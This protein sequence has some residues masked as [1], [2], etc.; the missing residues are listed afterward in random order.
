MRAAD[1]VI[2]ILRQQEDLS[3]SLVINRI[4]EDWVKRRTMYAPN[5]IAQTLDIPL[6]GVIP[7][8]EEVLRCLVT[9]KTLIES[10]ARIWQT[11]D[12]ILRSLLGE[13]SS[14]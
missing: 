5:V 9:R 7:E 14:Q 10:D 4:R 6:V 2:G 13:K 3:L 8:E 1:R 12:S 11:M